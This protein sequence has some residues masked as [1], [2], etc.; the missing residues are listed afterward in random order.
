MSAEQS[1]HG[2]DTVAGQEKADERGADSDEYFQESRRNSAV[3]YSVRFYQ[4]GGASF[5]AEADGAT[6]ERVVCTILGLARGQKEPLEP[7]TPRGEDWQELWADP[8]ESERN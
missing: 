7:E 2:E 3:Q 1:P 5:G 4:E 8:S 6:G